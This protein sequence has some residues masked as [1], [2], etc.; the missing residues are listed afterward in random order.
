MLA[1]NYIFFKY[2]E[3][4]LN[5]VLSQLCMCMLIPSAKHSYLLQVPTR[6]IL[7]AIVPLSHFCP[8]QSHFSP[9]KVIK[10]SPNNKS[11]PCSYQNCSLNTFFDE[12]KLEEATLMYTGCLIANYA[13]VDVFSN[14]HKDEYRSCD[15]YYTDTYFLLQ[16]LL[17]DMKC[18]YNRF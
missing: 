12:L 4:V 16:I 9:L 6:N 14:L 11:T 5:Y 2:S 15:N 1:Y 17:F 3:S 7:E 8:C 18:H 13:T 10:I